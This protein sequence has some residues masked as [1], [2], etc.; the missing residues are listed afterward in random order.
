MLDKKLEIKASWDKKPKKKVDPAAIEILS[1]IQK[2]NNWLAEKASVWVKDKVV[3]FRLLSTMINSWMSLI[4]SLEILRDQAESPKLQLVISRVIKRTAAGSSLSDAM[5]YHPDVFDVSS[6]WIIKAWE[7]SGKL[8]TIL[9]NL[10]DQIENFAKLSWKIKW[11]LM[12]PAVIMIIVVI[13]IVIIMT[14]VIPQIKEMFTSMWAKL[15]FATQLLIDTSDFLLAK[16][17]ILQINNLLLLVWLIIVLFIGFI[18][19]IKTKKWSYYFSL[20]LLRI[21][22]IKTILQKMIIAKFCRW[23]SI[24]IW[25]WMWIIEVLW[26]ISNM[27]WHEAYRIRTNRIAADVMQWLTMSQN[28]KRDV[29]Y[30]PPMLVSMIA[31]WEKTAKLEEVTLK[32]ADFYENEVNTIINNLMSLLEPL[33]IVVVWGS[34]WWIIIAIMLPIMSISDLIW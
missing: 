13:A 34:V 32:V 4:E 6:I 20:V 5:S 25:S 21:P 31:V 16:N 2:I 1:P 24:L 33:I 10:A 17:E 18:K 29:L 30:Y 7:K 12:Y 11:A 19:L 28:M 3:F 22:L 27:L 26:L 23:M 14:T 8:N 9:T 15:P